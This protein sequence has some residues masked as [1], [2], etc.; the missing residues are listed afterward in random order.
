M[1]AGYRLT[2]SARHA[3]GLLVLTTLVGWSGARGATAAADLFAPVK[4]QEA[5]RLAAI[6]KGAAQPPTCDYVNLLLEQGR[7]DDAV[8]LLDRLTGEPREVM[9]TKVRA[10]LT[11]R[12]YAAARPL[13]A[14]AEET[15]GPLVATESEALL[16]WLFA[17]DDAARIDTL[18]AWCPSV[19]FH[20]VLTPYHLAAGR[21]ALNLMNYDRAES[22]YVAVLDRIAGAAPAAFTPAWKAAA[23]TGLGLVQYKRRDYDGS[24]ARLTEAIGVQ[25]TPENLQALAE[26]LIR[27]GRT[28][29]AITA[30]EWAVRFNPYFEMGHYYLGNGYARRNYTE[31]RAAYP[32]AFA[33]AAGTRVLDAADSL[34]AAG[35]RPG[36]RAAYEA[37]RAA[38]PGWVDA[39]IRLASLDFEDGRFDSARDLAFGALRTCPEYGR[40]H[41]LLAK[42]LESQQMAVDVHR[43]ACEARFAATPMPDVPGIERFVTN[44]NSLSPRHRKQVALSIAP[45]RQFIPV[46][47]EGGSS[48]YI[49][50]LYMVLSKTPG[51]ETLR[52]QRIDYDSRLWDD[53]RGCGGYNTVTGIEDVERD[54][55]NKYNTVLHELSH[56]VHAVLTADQS[57]QIQE[58]YIRAKERDDRTKNGF[59]S[60]YAGGAVWEYFAEGVNALKT[61]KRDAYDPREMVRERLDRIDPDLRDHLVRLLAVTDVS[62]SYPV[63]WVGAGGDRVARGDVDGALPYY[64]KALARNP[65]EETALGS[66]VEALTLKGDCAEAMTVAE[67]AVAAHPGSG[68]IAV[69]AAEACWRSGRGLDA[70]TALLRA[71]RPRVT[72]AD[73]YRVDLALGRL[74]WVAGDAANSLAAYDLVVDHQSDSPEG[75][76]GRAS[77]LALAGRWE[78][79]FTGYDQAVRMRTGVTDLRCGYAQDLLRAG[80]VDAARAQLDEALLLDPEDP[81]ATALMGWV[82]MAGGRL[83]AARSHLQKALEWGPWCDMARILLGKVEARAGNAAA[84]EA[85]WAPVRERIARGAPPEYIFRTRLSTWESVHELPAVERALLEGK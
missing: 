34:L 26:T 68:P 32:G 72:P 70:A 17:V 28:D 30:A 73:Q 29:E 69:A 65:T 55:L 3:F 16:A 80:R 74:L 44:W 45:W 56:Q 64:R 10:L 42:A 1:T 31:L 40:A 33:D 4:E 82:E 35:N 60:R 12:N 84:A 85:A 19:S 15:F 5:R 7:A 54:I 6:E 58:L 49:K 79:A 83:D 37:V 71:A 2:R 50:P 11:V 36:A 46:L 27:L 20:P 21:L 75:L 48:Y 8:R 47:L 57:R 53:V 77:A 61:P 41:A 78:E 63:A 81:T 38:H 14:E 67:G 39:A 9:A 23:L 24:L 25:A 22:C 51:Q 59:I 43:P 76:W 18:T 66:L 62:A 52:D 13:I